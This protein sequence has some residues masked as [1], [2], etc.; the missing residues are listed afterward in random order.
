[1]AIA[2]KEEKIKADK[3]DKL[4]RVFSSMYLFVYW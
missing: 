1:V 2:K 3:K 4:P